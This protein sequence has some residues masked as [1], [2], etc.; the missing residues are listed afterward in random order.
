MHTPACDRRRRS[1]SLRQ[2]RRLSRGRSPTSM[3]AQQRSAS[4]CWSCSRP[5]TSNA[6]RVDTLRSSPGHGAPRSNQDQPYLRTTPR[7]KYIVHQ[8]SKDTSHQRTPHRQCVSA[9]RMHHCAALT[10]QNNK[11]NDM[12]R[13]EAFSAAIIGP[14]VSSG[15]A[16]L[17]RS[18]QHSNRRRAP[19]PLHRG[20]T[21]T[22]V[23]DDSVLRRQPQCRPR[24]RTPTDC[25]NTAT[26]AGAGRLPCKS[27]PIGAPHSMPSR[28]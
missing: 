11:P 22:E 15:P 16:R 12:S 26:V 1:L 28:R 27:A 14:V 10:P 9:M 17:R 13:I 6:H 20:E 2:L 23:G 8:R 4:R 7:L 21:L 19:H 5:R 3:L 24:V 25:T 18:A